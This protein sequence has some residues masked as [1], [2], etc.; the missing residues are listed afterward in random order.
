MAYTKKDFLAT[1]REETLPKFIAELGGLERSFA[2][3]TC[4]IALATWLG[5]LPNEAKHIS[6]TQIINWFQGSSCPIFEI[7]RDRSEFVRVFKN[8]I[9]DNGFTRQTPEAFLLMTLIFEYDHLMLRKFKSELK[10]IFGQSSLFQKHKDKIMAVR[11]AYVELGN[12]SEQED[13]FSD[14]AG[15]EIE[16]GNNGSLEVRSPAFTNI[17]PLRRLLRAYQVLM[18]RLEIEGHLPPGYYNSLH[19]RFGY[20]PDSSE[21]DPWASPLVDYLAEFQTLCGLILLP[22]ERTFR[23]NRLGQVNADKSDQYEVNTHV[24][25]FRMGCVASR[26]NL[27]SYINFLKLASG[28]IGKGDPRPITSVTTKI[29]KALVLNGLSYWMPF[30][31]VVTALRVSR[32]LE[33]FPGA[34]YFQDV[35]PELSAE[36]LDETVLKPALKNLNQK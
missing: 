25:Q 6:V 14:H 31:Q 18:T 33:N 20:W 19:V 36:W 22:L 1:L 26:I 35:Y 3:H 28:L 23:S 8:L 2:I 34:I 30:G 12:S 29:R 24:I 13:K 16:P 32:L 4:H 27:D 11:K 21:H 15:I 10:K 17:D 5:T 9:L 7:C